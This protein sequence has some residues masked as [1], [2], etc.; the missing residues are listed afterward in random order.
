MKNE[1]EIQFEPQNLFATVWSPDEGKASIGVIVAVHGVGSSG[2]REYCYYG[3]YMERRG[4]TVIAFDCPGFGHWQ[5]KEKRALK[6]HVAMF[7]SSVHASL[8]KAREIVPNGPL[9]LTG[10]SMGG[11][12]ITQYVTKYAKTPS[13]QNPPKPEYSK[14]VGYLMENPTPELSALVGIVPGVGLS[15]PAGMTAIMKIIGTLM[16]NKTINL[17]E[18]MAS[19]SDMTEEQLKA[20]M[21]DMALNYDDPPDDGYGTEILSFGFLNNFLSMIKKNGLANKTYKRWPADVPTIF[22]T[23][24]EDP[25][26]KPDQVKLYF[27]GMP[28]MDKEY[29][30]YAGCSHPLQ[31]HK[32]REEYFEDIHQFLISCTRDGIKAL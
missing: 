32:K 5:P 21:E 1:I 26:V 14:K 7:P 13:R 10:L 4:W 6:E 8:L 31:F 22:L 28:E 12:I 24:E 9:V 20:M 2:A 16:P 25:V 19:S 11:A 18:K 15:A 23:G 29:H 27:D 3:P 17:F 30:C